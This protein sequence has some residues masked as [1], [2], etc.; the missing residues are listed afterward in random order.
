MRFNSWI[1][2]NAFVRFFWFGL[3][4]FTIPLQ[5]VASIETI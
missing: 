3:I 2:C 4:L 1:S 5:F